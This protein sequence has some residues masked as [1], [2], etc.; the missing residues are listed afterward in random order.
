MVRTRL[1]SWLMGLAA[2]AL[3][4]AAVAGQAYTTAN[5]NLRAGPDTDYPVLRWVPEGTTVEVH[6]CLEEYQW[7]DVEAMGER[8]WMH[9]GYLAY[10]YQQQYVPVVNYGRMEIAR[11]TGG[12][13]LQMDLAGRFDILMDFVR[14]EEIYD[15]LEKSV[16]RFDDIANQVQDIV[17]EHV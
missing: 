4:A 17:I 5:V 14:G 15:H 2:L 12:N 8:G 9:G 10:P 7:C 1:R 16:D 6:G 11:Q 13:F 3:P